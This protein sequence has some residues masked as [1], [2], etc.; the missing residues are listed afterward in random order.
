MGR[1]NLPKYRPGSGPPVKQALTARL[2]G[3]VEE[4]VWERPEI[5]ELRV[6]SGDHLRPA[7]CYPHS[8]GR[9]LVGQEVALNTWAVSLGL[10][11]GGYDF[12]VSAGIENEVQDCPGHILKL[13]YTPNQ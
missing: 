8:T 12:V 10:G 13:R 1:G 7:I 9:A 2:K 5:Q 4:I 3:V 6:R 11:S